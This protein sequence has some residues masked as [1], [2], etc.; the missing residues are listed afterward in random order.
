MQR[1]L[2]STL[3]AAG[4]T[5][6]VCQTLSTTAVAQVENMAQ[7]ARSQK[8]MTRNVAPLRETLAQAGFEWGADLHIRI[9]KEEEELEV[10][11]QDG[12]TFRLFATHP[13]CSYSGRLGPK[14]R[15]GDNQAPEGFYFVPPSAFNPWSDYH[16]SFNLGYPNA[17]DRAQGR[18]GNYLMVHGRCVSIGCYAMTNPVIEKIW[19]LA[20]AAYQDGQPFFRTHIF[21]FRM[22]EENMS[23]HTGSRHDAFWENLK[24]GYDAFEAGHIPPNVEV[25]EGQYVIENE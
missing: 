23:K 10:W 21:P 19:T 3:L 20:H 8:A 2:T 17:F 22:T 11:L 6:L 1:S 25:Q 13:I 24:E 15:Q 14:M 4:I 16:L 5:L 18:T 7:T 9:Y 12:D